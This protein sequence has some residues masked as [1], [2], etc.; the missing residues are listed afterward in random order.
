MESEWESGFWIF[1][2]HPCSLIFGKAIIQGLEELANLVFI[3]AG[4]RENYGSFTIIEG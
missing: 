2:R 1:I 4:A 3:A